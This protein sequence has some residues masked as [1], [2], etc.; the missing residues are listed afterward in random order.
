MKLLGLLVVMLL[1][2]LSARAQNETMPDLSTL[3]VTGSGHLA[4]TPDTAFVTLA[5]E[6][7]GKSLADAQRQNSR[8]MQKVVERLQALQIP[9]ERIQTS[10]FTVS[11]HYRPLSKRPTAPP[12]AAPEIIGYSVSNSVTVELHHPEQAAAVI[13]ESLTAGANRFHGLHWALRDE[14][15][16]R[17]TA[18]KQAAA[19]AR[20][21]AA[22]LSGAL[23][24]KLLRLISAREDSQVVRPQSH[25][26]RSMM[27]MEASADAP[28][29]A[30]EVKVEA[31]VTLVYEV[32]PE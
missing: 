5:V 26:A 1:L 20:E 9:K 29:F 14:Q 8:V 30:G 32:G 21:K 18:L 10:S 4:S 3:T 15:P 27:A 16:A 19:T 31:T 28:I 12:S 6:T 2:P 17:L 7:A 22:A 23:K 24:V 13:D 25:M 11:P